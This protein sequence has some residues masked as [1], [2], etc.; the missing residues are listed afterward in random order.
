MMLSAHC[1]KPDS[2]MDVPG[3][4]AAGGIA[5]GLMA[6]AD[7]Q[8]L[9]GFDLVSAWLDLEAR[10]AAADLVITGEGCFDESSLRGK[11]PGAVV[12]RALASGKLVHV[13]AGQLASNAG[14]E[15]GARGAATMHAITPP[16]LPLPEALRQARQHL[17]ASV[18]RAFSQR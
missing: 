17:G 9:P 5:F 2:L 4:G 3:A 11:G 6:A 14:A 15:A 7:A 16:E 10:L 8:L 12:A 1:G 13:F 18:R